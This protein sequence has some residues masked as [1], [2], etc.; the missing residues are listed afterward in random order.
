MMTRDQDEHVEEAS[1]FA[2]AD[3]LYLVR[4]G[5]YGRSQVRDT[6]ECMK[7]ILVIVEFQA[8]RGGS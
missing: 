3:L 7:E 1:G 6:I 8:L 4:Q 5:R 2:I